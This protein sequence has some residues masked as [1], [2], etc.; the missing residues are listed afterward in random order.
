[1]STAAAA[2]SSPSLE[3]VPAQYVIMPQHGICVVTGYNTMEAGGISTNVT[4]LRPVKELKSTIMKPSHRLA[5][6][7]IRAPLDA[8]SMQKILRGAFSEVKG[9]GGGHWHHREAAYNELIQSGAAENMAIALNKSLSKHRTPK[10]KEENAGSELPTDDK[11]TINY[12]ERQIANV[13]LKYLGEELAH[14]TGMREWEAR[15]MILCAALVPGYAAKIKI[16]GEK[17]APP[18]MDAD[19]FQEIFGHAPGETIGNAIK[20]DMTARAPAANFYQG[21]ERGNGKR[22]SGGSLREEKQV[23]RARMK[24]TARAASPKSIAADKAAELLQSIPEGN[25]TFFKNETDMVATVG[26][27]RSIYVTAARKLDEQGFQIVAQTALRRTQKLTMEEMAKALDLPL[28]ETIKLRD[29]AMNTLIKSTKFTLGGSHTPKFFHPYQA[30]VAKEER[31]KETKAPR[32]H[33][34]SKPPREAKEKYVVAE[35]NRAL[36]K[37]EEHMMSPKGM[38]RGLFLKAA[39]VLKLD[40]FQIVAQTALRR[41]GRLSME[42]VA[43]ALN[44]PLEDAITI[45]NRAMATLVQAT[46]YDPNGPRAPSILKPYEVKPLFTRAAKPVSVTENVQAIDADIDFADTEEETMILICVPKEALENSCG[47]RLDIS[48]DKVAGAMPQI[49]KA[50]TGIKILPDPHAAKGKAEL[51]EPAIQPPPRT[52]DPS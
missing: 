15:K 38:M 2:Q 50:E 3:I 10:W 36:F 40:E 23:A 30:P 51:A 28:D 49:L 24:P 21:Y 17:A 46:G 43:V 44:L 11:I 7:G 47:L 27:M 37:A 31:I 34:A 35:E 6:V 20:V 5:Q 45:R 12:S 16:S 19:Q 8:Q 4:V 9:D 26:I 32:E 18:L 33:K 48:W 52:L 1:M 13:A 22:F 25:R 41:G 14:A 39:R 42:Q 29:A